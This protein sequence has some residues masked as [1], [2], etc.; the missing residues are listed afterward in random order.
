M[1]GRFSGYCSR[2]GQPL[3]RRTWLSATNSPS[4]GARSNALVFA[5]G[6]VSSGPGFPGPGRTGERALS[7]SSRT[8]SSAGT[9]RASGSTGA[10]RV[11]IAATAGRQCLAKFPTS[12]VACRKRIR[13]GVLREFTASYSSSESKSRRRRCPST[14]SA[15]AS[16]HYN[17]GELFSTTTRKTSCPS[18]SSRCLR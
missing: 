1:C 17:R 10:G 5:G 2:G 4:C 16:H 18:I 15:V 6:I 7:S 13:C 12:S 14:W 3:S 8:P 9:A 11:D